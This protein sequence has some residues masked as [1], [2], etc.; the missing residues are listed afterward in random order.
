MIGAAGR[1]L[2]TRRRSSRFGLIV[3][4]YGS[5]SSGARL[6]TEVPGRPAKGCRL[7]IRI[8]TMADPV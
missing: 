7:E 2:V 5:S 1:V 4:A 3:F 6:L 8:E